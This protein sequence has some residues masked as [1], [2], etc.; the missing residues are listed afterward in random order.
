MLKENKIISVLTIKNSTLAV[1]LAKCL[2]DSGIRNLE[3][4]L[5]TKE[6]KKAIELISNTNLDFNIGVGTVLDLEDL[7]FAKDIGANFALSPCTDIEII[8]DSINT[9]L[10]FELIDIKKINYKNDYKVKSP[11]KSSS[12]FMLTNEWQPSAE[13]NEI[14]DMTDITKDFYKTKLKEFKIY[15]CERGQKKNNWNSTFIDFMRR[16]WTKEINSE[17]VLPHRDCCCNRSRSTCPSCE[18]CG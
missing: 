11:N 16:E 3:I 2:F 10:K 15:W 9:L 4:T 1:D 12:S 7:Y 14:L 13:A 17:K 18:G 8:K 5:R 6:A